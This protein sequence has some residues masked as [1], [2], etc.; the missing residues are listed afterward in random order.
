MT[1]EEQTERSN[2]F[3]HVHSYDEEVSIPVRKTKETREQMKV[4]LVKEIADILKDLKVVVNN[5]IHDDI[6]VNMC[7]RYFNWRDMVFSLSLGIIVGV[8]ISHL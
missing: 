7:N 6:N 4:K 1:K 2:K 3:S 8:V 5:E